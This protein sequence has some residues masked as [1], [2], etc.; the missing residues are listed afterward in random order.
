MTIGIGFPALILSISI[1]ILFIQETSQNLTDYNCFFKILLAICIAI[2]AFV[3]ICVLFPIIAIFSCGLTYIWIWILIM[4][5]DMPMYE[6]HARGQLSEWVTTSYNTAS[7]KYKLCC[8]NSMIV[9]K[10]YHDGQNTKSTDLSRR[11]LLRQS[12]Q[13]FEHASLTDFRQHYNELS[14]MS[15][16]DK[17]V[18]NSLLIDKTESQILHFLQKY[19]LFWYLIMRIPNMLIPFLIVIYLGLHYG[20]HIIF[21]SSIQN[22][23]LLIFLILDILFICIAFILFGTMTKRLYYGWHL[24]FAKDSIYK[25]V[26]HEL[27]AY[28]LLLYSKE[29]IEEILSEQGIA[30]IIIDYIGIHD[31]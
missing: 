11:Y 4:A 18:L 29:L 6:I 19:S 5:M 14:I 13:S 20:H 1:I 17:E 21:V 27:Y 24:I 2:I 23:L 31:L 26:K 22:Y 30:D 7:D 10:L 3:C 25:K 9:D 8:I 15:R 16:L 28:L 12:V